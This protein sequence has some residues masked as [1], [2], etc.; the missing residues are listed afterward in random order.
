MEFGPFKKVLALSLQPTRDP[1]SNKLQKP[2]LELNW[3]DIPHLG[4]FRR[5]PFIQR[6]R[7][8]SQVFGGHFLLVEA[9]KGALF[10][11]TG[12]KVNVLS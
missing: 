11:D 8:P 6:I 1:S 5:N 12:E 7:L 4:L 2:L 9:P 10:R 3:K